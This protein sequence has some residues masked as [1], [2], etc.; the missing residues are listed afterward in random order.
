PLSK[1][2]LVPRH[3]GDGRCR[4]CRRDPDMKHLLMTHADQKRPRL[5]LRGGARAGKSGAFRRD[6]MDNAAAAPA[7]LTDRDRAAILAGILTSMLL[8]ALDQSIVT[9]AMPTIGAA[10]GDAHY[11]PW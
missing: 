8:A 4:H 3:N 6:V 1:S 5:P 2:A 7:E 9:P 11:L 10:L